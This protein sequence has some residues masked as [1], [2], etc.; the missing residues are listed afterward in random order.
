MQRNASRS[1][2]VVMKDISYV[3]SRVPDMGSTSHWLRSQAI[4]SRALE[5]AAGG[6]DFGQSCHGELSMFMD[7]YGRYITR[8]HHMYIYIYTHKSIHIYIC[9]HIHIYIYLSMYVYS[10]YM[11]LHGSQMLGQQ[12]PR[13]KGTSADNQL[14]GSI[15]QLSVH[16]IVALLPQSCRVSYLY[17][18]VSYSSFTVAVFFHFECRSSHLCLLHSAAYMSLYGIDTCCDGKWL[19]VL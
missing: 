12:R 15:D 11:Y 14:K 6:D 4:C 8:K 16:F 10:I 9:I 13:W 7:I 19:R 18:V 17:P 5:S 2:R 1:R 3:S